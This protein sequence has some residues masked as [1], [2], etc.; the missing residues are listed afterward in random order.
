MSAR[1]AVLLCS[2]SFGA[3]CEA[4]LPGGPSAFPK[5]VVEGTVLSEGKPIPNDGV[6]W[7]TFYPEGSSLGD[8]AVCRLKPDGSYRCDHVP[9]GPLN[10]RIDVA[11]SVSLPPVIRR[12]INRLRGPE[13]PLRVVSSTG[14]ATR[15]DFDLALSPDPARP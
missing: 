2:A 9:V 12:R 1:L 7:V 10:V 6:G 4:T 8:A 11:N 15:Y 14:A 5:A 13:S 3:G